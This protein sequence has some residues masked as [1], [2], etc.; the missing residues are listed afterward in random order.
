LKWIGGFQCL[1]KVWQKAKVVALRTTFRVQH[2]VKVEKY[3]A[4]EVQP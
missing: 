4:I 2:S 3:D 1:T